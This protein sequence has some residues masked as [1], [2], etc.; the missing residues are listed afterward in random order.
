MSTIREVLVPLMQ[1]AQLHRPAALGPGEIYG[2]SALRRAVVSRPAHSS[3]RSHSNARLFLQLRY[4]RC[5]HTKSTDD[6]SL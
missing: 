6:V 3:R 1:I 4:R 2:M 5:S